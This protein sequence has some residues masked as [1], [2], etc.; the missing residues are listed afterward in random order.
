MSAVAI[1]EPPTP[2]EPLT[3]AELDVLI[4]E[5][6]GAPGAEDAAQKERPWRIASI[7][8]AE[9]AMAKVAD[10]DAA[11]AK[12]DDQLEQWTV[13]YR[14]WHADAA[15]DIAAH[16][17]FFVAH[18][19]AHAIAEREASGGKTKTVTLP[20]G[21]IATTHHKPKVSITDEATLIAW[22]EDNLEPEQVDAI[23][24]TSK[25][26]LVSELKPVT[27]IIEVIDDLRIVSAP[28][29]CVTEEW[30]AADGFFPSHGDAISCPSCGEEALVGQWEVTASH[31]EVWDDAGR[32]VP[33]AVV[34]AGRITA[35]VT[36][37][38]PR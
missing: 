15:T 19:E 22:A 27:Q 3:G 14:A 33:G 24:K 32:P 16:R 10:L 31:P 29:G 9:W 21:K 17:R 18:L 20:S 23:V 25:R 30:P 37:P 6:G 7:A 36:L 38:G 8:D 4:R 26:A 2:E 13:R 28:C 12:I 11:Q 34:E 5:P 1:P 35:K